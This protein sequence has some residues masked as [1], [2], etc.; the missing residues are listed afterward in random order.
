M[1]KPR[2]FLATEVP[3]HIRRRIE[4]S[5]DVVEVTGRGEPS[6]EQLQAILPTVQGILAMASLR[7][8]KELLDASTALRVISI[9]GV[10]Y[11]KVDLAQA[12]ARGVLVCNTP[13][14]LTRAV[15]DLTFLLILALAR[16][17]NENMQVLR[18][19]GWRDGT[20][21][22]LGVDLR[23]KVLSVLGLGGI[24][25]DVARTAQGFGMRTIYYKPSR[26]FDAEDSGLAHYRDRDDIFRD[27]DFVTVH[28]PLNE[29]TR[30]SIGKREFELMKPTA[31][32]V[33][34]SRG[35]TVDENAL[36]RALHERRIA[37]AGLDVMRKEPMDPNHPL[38]S[39]PNVIL[40]P[41]IGSATMETRLA[42]ME[43]A[44]ENL[45]AA[46]TGGVPK[47]VV[48]PLVLPAHRAM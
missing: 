4:G 5:C 44:A 33:N 30:D 15:A 6:R 1:T 8:D 14:V 28:V 45:I 35:V 16:R 36:V 32:F 24:G 41:H 42:M 38:C 39:L 27:A 3:D 40:L 10:G 48:N 23:G 18:S 43:L 29:T 25:K 20:P 7:L 46:V 21:R 34:T 47:A 31:Y 9:S 37:G 17:M 19:G 22:P 13:G 12:T 2:V 26:D 11:D